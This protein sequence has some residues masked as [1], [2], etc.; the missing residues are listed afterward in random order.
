MVIS[1][2]VESEI[3]GMKVRYALAMMYGVLFWT[4]WS[5]SFVGNFVDIQR[6]P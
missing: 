3:S 1:T 2:L 6:R 5:F 4:R